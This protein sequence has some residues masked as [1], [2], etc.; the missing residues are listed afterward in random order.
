MPK[1]A[2][3]PWNFF[4]GAGLI[5]GML[6]GLA[7]GTASL[8]GAQPTNDNFASAITI[9]NLSGSILGTNLSATTQ[10]GERTNIVTFDSGTNTP[11]G[12]S[13]WYKWVAPSSGSITFDT[14]G[15]DFD[16]VIGVYTGAVLTNLTEIAGDDESGGN[17]NSQVNFVTTAGTTYYIAVYGYDNDPFA[18]EGDI[19]LNWNQPS[20][21][22]NDNFASAIVVS[23]TTGTTNGYNIAA[24]LELNEPNTVIVTYPFPTAV[25]NS[26]WYAWTAPANGTVTFDTIGSDFD[27]L[28]GVYTGNSVSTLSL[29]TASDDITGGVN[30]QSQVSF[31]AVANTT[32]YFAVYGYNQPPTTQGNVILNWSMQ[33]SDFAAGT[34]RFTSKD[35]VVS[36]KESSPAIDGGM[37]PKKNS[38]DPVGGRVTVTR[39]GGAVGRVLVGYTVTNG[40][41]PSISDSLVFGINTYFTNIDTSGN[42]IGYTNVYATN[43]QAFTTVPNPSTFNGMP[44]V[45][46]SQNCFLYS[47]NYVITVSNMNG[48]VVMTVSSNSL[49]FTFGNTF[50]FTNVDTGSGTNSFA[51]NTF[52]SFVLSTNFVPAAIA[53]DPKAPNAVWDY[54]PVKGTLV[55]NDYEMSKDIYVTVNTNNVGQVTNFFGG[56]GN[57]R[58]AEI[59]VTL[60]SVALDTNELQT[61]PLPTIDPTNSTTKVDVLNEWQALG[62]C[63]A[64]GFNVFNFERSTLSVDRTAGEA[65]VYVQRG[66]LNDVSKDYTIY[67]SIDHRKKNDDWNTFQ[68][69]A[70]SDYAIPDNATKGAPEGVVDFDSSSVAIGSVTWKKNDD[71]P[72]AIHIPINDNN[73]VE[74]NKDFVVQFYEDDAHLWADTAIPGWITACTVTILYNKEPAGAIDRG[75]NVESGTNPLPGVDGPVSAVAVQP[76][77]KILVGGNFVIYNTTTSYHIARANTNGLADAAFSA[78]TALGADG[79]VKA[80]ALD[81]NTNI[82]IGGDFSSFNGTQRNGIARLNPNG[83]LDDTVFKPGLGFDSSVS[84]ILVQPDGQILVAGNFREYNSTNRNCIIRLNPDGSVDSTFDPHGGP[85]KDFFDQDT[86]INSMALQPDG[87]IVIGGDFTSVDGVP[88]NYIARLNA[89]G[90]L[91][92]TFDPGSG[93]DFAVNSVAVQTNGL[94]VVGGAFTQLGTLGGSQGIARLNPDGSVDTTFNAGSGANNTVYNVVLQPDGDIVFAGIF[95]SVNQTRR[96]GLARLL[97]DG[98]LDTGFMDTAYNQ[99]AGMINPY[100][101]SDVNGPNP[102]NALALQP[103]GNI[104]IGGSFSQVGGGSSRHDIR[105]RANI[106]RILG[107]STPGPGNIQLNSDSYTVQSGVTYSV[108]VERVNGT[109]G[110]AQATIQPVPLPPGVGAATPGIDYIFSGLAMSWKTSYSDTWMVSDG[111]GGG[112]STGFTTL[113]NGNPNTIVNLQMTSPKGS[114]IFFLGGENIPLGVALG[115]SLS[116]LTIIQNHLNRGVLNLNPQGYFVN[117]NVAGGNAVVSVSRTGGSAG[118]VTVNYKTLDGTARAGSDYSSRSSPP[119]L[120]FG[121]GVTNQ[122]FT[123]PIINNTTNQPDR[124]VLLQIYTPSGGATLGTTNSQLVI[125]DDDNQAGNVNFLNGV[126]VVIGTSNVMTYGGNEN[127]SFATITV[128]R[129]GGNVGTMVASVGTYGGTATNGVNYTGFTNTVTWNSGVS[130]P[131]NILIPIIDDNLV[132]SNRTLNLK[133]FA[134][135]VN[136][137]NNSFAMGAYT[138]GMLTITNTDAPGTLHF[139]LS[140]Y[141]FREDGGPAIVPVTRTGGSAGTVSVNYYTADNSAVSNIDYVTTNGILVFTNGEL[142][143]SIRVPIIDNPDTDGNRS[144]TLWLT[145]FSPASVQ[146]SPSNAPLTIIDDESQNTPPGSGDTGYYGLAGFNSSVFALAL[147][148]SDNKLIVGGDFTLANGVG[149]NRIARL[150]ADG[151]LDNKFSS[152][153]PTQ[154]A[155]DAVHSIVVQTDGRIL[156]GGFFTNFNSAVMNRIARLNYNGSLDSTFLPGAGANSTV[157]AIAESFL[158]GQ[159][160]ILVGGAFTSMG[161]VARNGIARLN[162]NGTIDSSFGNT[163]GANGAV[164]AIALQGDGKILIGGDFTSVNNVLLNHVAR[165]NTDGSVDLTFTNASVNSAIGPD[166]SVRT[167]AVQL[168]GKILIGGIFTSVSGATMNHIAR[169]NADGTTDTSFTPGL[170]A[171]DTVETISLQADTRIV[172]GGDFTQCNGVTRNRVTRLNSNGTTDLTINFGLGADGFVSSSVIQPD[173]NIILGGGF[174]N[175]DGVAHA[176]VVRIYGGS[177]AGSGALYFGSASSPNFTVDQTNGVAVISVRRSGGTA[178]P[179]LDGSGNIV[180]NFSMTN[181]TAIAGIDYSNVN[182]NVSFPPGEVFQTVNVP[183]ISHVSTIPY[184]EATMVLTSNALTAPAIIGPVN[185][186]TLRIINSLSSINFAATNYSVGKNVINGMGTLFVARYG[187]TNATSTVDYFTTTNGTAVAG[188]DYTPS[189]G[190]VTFNPGETNKSLQIPI[191]NNNLPEGNRTV[192]VAL[193]NALG[194]ALASP[195]NS[196]L[197]IID[198]VQA[199]GQFALSTNSFTAAEGSGFVAIQIVRFNGSSGDVNVNFSTTNS[200]TAT[201]GVNY[202]TT[203]GS[204]KFF[205]GV[206]TV[207]TIYVPLIDNNLVQGTVNFS[208]NISLPPGAATLASPSNAIVSI[209]D[210]D[211]GVAFASP[212]NYV[213]ETNSSAI[214]FVQRIGGTTNAFQVNFATTNGTAVAGVNY[215][216]T[217]GTLSFVPGEVIKTITVPLLRDPRVTGDLTFGLALSNPNGNAQLASPSNTLVVVQDGDAGLSFT[218]TTMDVAKNAGSAA[219]TV[220]C[221]NPAIEPPG[222]SNSTPITVHYSTSNGSAIAGQD[223][224]AVSGTLTFTNGIGTNIFFVPIINNSLITGTRTFTVSLDSPTAPGKL[225]SPS[226]QVV[227]IIDSNSGLSFSSATYSVLRTGVAATIT[228]LRT[229]NTNTVSTVNFATA[230]GTAIAG[231]DYFATNGVLT[232]TNGDLSKTFTVTVI[233]GNTVQP[234]KTVLLQL[235]SPANGVLVPPSAATLT[236]RDIGGNLVIPAGSRLLQENV[237]T[238]GI[239]DPGE[240]V[241]MLFGFRA[242]GG[243]NVPNLFATLLAT[244]GVTAPAP[245]TAVNYGPLVVGGPS[246]SRVFGFTANGTNGQSIAATFQLNNGL[247]NIGTATFVYTLGTWTQTFSRTNTIIIND[248]TTASPYPSGLTLSNLNGVV[249]KATVTLTNLSH[250]SESDVNVLLLAPNQADTLLMSHAGTA[251]IPM[252]HATLTFSDAA[253]NSLPHANSQAITNGVYKPSSFAP[254]PIFP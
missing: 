203:N 93:A 161:G 117:E 237:L 176:R 61:I 92:N 168:D 134:T 22:P 18:D 28:L 132:T 178:G 41:L 227:N 78:A 125:I 213:N 150:N 11:V 43:F 79:T 171:N 156:V 94:I 162:D 233:A 122:T 64:F 101:N 151:T 47:T 166:G 217:A 210:N 206:D 77:G 234:D 152:Y 52:G 200:G 242:A 49:P 204:V 131:T 17:S 62:S 220:I 95:T 142:S 245:G 205:A 87:K 115:R 109:L 179:N 38:G 85:S 219:I 80:I 229:D 35:Y 48:F 239:I 10:V 222:G 60:D 136:N 76:D 164:Y 250:R 121:D 141:S 187:G 143:K 198:T 140:S 89:D 147:E 216:T 126:P 13:V 123:I 207:K 154:G 91:D 54:L 40:T 170:G 97:P 24:T 19:Q 153:L 184:V 59:S 106:A 70:G 194:S 6:L 9:T 98:S 244:N 26:I 27:T 46:V 183:V 51:T 252:T 112:K 163:V 36:Q 251:A 69:Q 63:G 160:K 118:L 103:D 68:L 240:Q 65:V 111:E 99:F 169:L 182:V 30:L 238:N 208:V 138:N 124:T 8:A 50:S 110:P 84:C 12:S 25:S 226:N 133:I 172:L 158:G 73:T 107:G 186:A 120:S 66:F 212:T 14:I 33:T 144:L 37:H 189:S 39:T 224:T 180:V 100:Y 145:N 29:I 58:N 86:I 215:T 135:K 221:S 181:D 137:A 173:G 127:V 2:G 108:G 74:F 32:Y 196:T 218:N 193:T 1:F 177:M 83:S 202:V 31:Y 230:N 148:P 23:G 197:T 146:G 71:D 231:T 157:L 201:P 44:S 191:I 128:S 16:T 81:A 129:L 53:R 88:L 3:T 34:F 236:I 190:T 159:R 249:V 185:P 214:I 225:T 209:T 75:F 45:S 7:L 20:P 15:S 199:P 192:I 67:Y 188:T 167:I 241:S 4:Q 235:F 195:S 82:Y 228:V 232:F 174:L 114:D 90:S 130:G 248:N 116:P 104:V 105:A 246:A 56:L 155:S 113:T 119:P 165:L 254:T 223:Y 57:G 21:P 149:R 96:V 102:I 211:F 5:K 42:V 253:T 139:N 175:Y 247:T 243:T 55:F 72:K